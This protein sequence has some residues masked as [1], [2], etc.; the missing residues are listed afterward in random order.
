MHIR[1]EIKGTTKHLMHTAITK[2]GIEHSHDT[3]ISLFDTVMTEVQQLS[4]AM[5]EPSKSAPKSTQSLASKSS[6]TVITSAKKISQPVPK[7]S[8]KTASSGNRFAA[9]DMSF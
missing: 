5:Q 8:K 9:L 2:L 3:L 1:D 7:K 4:N 6:K